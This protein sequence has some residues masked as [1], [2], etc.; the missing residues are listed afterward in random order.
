ML[1]CYVHRQAQLGMWLKSFYQVGKQ[2][3]ISEGGLYEDLGLIFQSRFFLK[4]TDCFY[5][6]SLLYR[7]IAMKGEL[8]SILS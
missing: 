8:L 7:Q 4:T 6:L 2:P 1:A 3:V 5:G